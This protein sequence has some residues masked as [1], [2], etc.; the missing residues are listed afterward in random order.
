MGQVD[1]INEAGNAFKVNVFRLVPSRNPV[2]RAF[3]FL[4]I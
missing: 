2:G 4:L 3:R 1:D